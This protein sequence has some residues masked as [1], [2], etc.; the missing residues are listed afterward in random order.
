MQ[1]PWELIDYVILH[2]LVH[3]KHLNHSPEFWRALEELSPGARA[4][5]KKIKSHKPRVEPF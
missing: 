5:Q 1:L 2:E 4:L 3:T